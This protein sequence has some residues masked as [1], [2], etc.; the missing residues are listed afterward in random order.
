VAAPVIVLLALR[1]VLPWAVIRSGLSF[2]L[3]VVA[4]TM[5]VSI[6]TAWFSAEFPSILGGLSGLVV[7]TLLARSGW[8]LAAEGKVTGEPE[9]P[10]VQ[11]DSAVP[12]PPSLLLAAFPILGVITLL[13][14]TR[15]GALGLKGL[16][17]LETP[18]ASADLGLVGTAWIS[19]A[20][21]VGLREILGTDMG[22]K[23]ALLYVPFIIPFVV[24]SL[25]SIPLLRMDGGQ[26]R[27]AWGESLDRLR[28]PAIAMA[29]A[30]VLVKLM[31]LGNL[32]SPAMIL[33][34]NLGEATGQSWPWFA[35]LL[36][37]LGAFFSGS[38]TV[39]NLTFAPIQMAIAD[40]QN[41][42]VAL[43]LALQSVGG[44]MGNMICIHNIVAV[45]AILGLH[46]RGTPRKVKDGK[47]N[48][49]GE[50]GEAGAAMPQEAE[51]DSHVGGVADVLRLTFGP[52][53]VYAVLAA[54]VGALIRTIGM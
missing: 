11:A 45:A 22:W 49:A 25:I 1:I 3:A 33:G 48:A 52:M 36:G 53:V 5:G 32:L 19:P 50:E 12:P 16:L 51:D 26:V 17:N 18:A 54:A 46:E 31:M 47:P 21:V 15:I 10:A 9:P 14:V 7:A 30:L 4:A 40:T 28:N 43:I 6:T 44:A 13:A 29:G 38:N 8:G 34:R 24:I 39:S 2:V 41:L 35:A 37:A 20:L 27:R 23:M 42:S